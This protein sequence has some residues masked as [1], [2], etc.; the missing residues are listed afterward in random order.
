MVNFGTLGFRHRNSYSMKG[1]LNFPFET[2][3]SALW[4]SPVIS[5]HLSLS[6]ILLITSSYIKASKLFEDPRVT[7]IKIFE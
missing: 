6:E 2:D 5:F 7:G 4:R 1:E 3:I